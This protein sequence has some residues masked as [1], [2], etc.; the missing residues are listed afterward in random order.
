MPV[1][2]LLRSHFQQFFTG[3]LTTGCLRDYLISAERTRFLYAI[4]KLLAAI[5]G[6]GS[7]RRGFSIRC[8]LRALFIRIY[9]ATELKKEER[10][11][12]S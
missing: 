3:S 5:R 4:D 10:K 12:M 6:I 8:R 9:A 1:S 11:V 2:L 7:V